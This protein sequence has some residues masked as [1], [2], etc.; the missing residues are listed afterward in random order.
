MAKE[1]HSTTYGRVKS[2]NTIYIMRIAVIT[3]MVV[4]C[5]TYAA[6][7]EQS[8]SVAADTVL[9]ESREQTKQLK[10]IADALE[11]QNLRVERGK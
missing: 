3:V 10:R 7:E 11:A 1:G 6:M 8:K 4:L 5:L 2:D 9:T